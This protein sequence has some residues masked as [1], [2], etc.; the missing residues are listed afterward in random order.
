MKYIILLILL[1]L[2]VWAENIGIPYVAQIDDLITKI[3]VIDNQNVITLEDDGELKIWDYTNGHFNYIFPIERISNFEL[4]DDK[5]LLITAD[6]DNKIIFWNLKTKQNEMLI[7]SPLEYIDLMVLAQNNKK[8]ALVD[9]HKGEI[10]IVNLITEKVENTFHVS[11]IKK[12][13]FSENENQI[14]LLYENGEVHLMDLIDHGKNFIF[15]KYRVADMVVYKNKVICQSIVNGHNELLSIH[16]ETYETQNF[17]NQLISYQNFKILDKYL[18]LK[19]SNILHLLDLATYKNISSIPIMLGKD[20]EYDITIDRD[21][22]VLAGSGIRVIDIKKMTKLHELKQA[23]YIGK[24]D[25]S[26]D[27]KNISLSYY[28]NSMKLQ[29]YTFSLSN[30][31]MVS[32]KYTIPESETLIKRDD[33]LFLE[34]GKVI[35]V[36]STQKTNEE[37]VAIYN[38]KMQQTEVYFSDNTQKRLLFI[39]PNQLRL[40]FVSNDNSELFTERFEYIPYIDR[41]S[42]STIDRWNVQTGKLIQTLNIPTFGLNI[43]MSNNKKYLAYGDTYVHIYKKKDSVKLFM[44]D[45]GNWVIQIPDGSFI[46]SKDAR[47]YICMKMDDEQYVPINNEAYQKFNNDTK[48]KN[49]FN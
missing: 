16:L 11:G 17:F 35:S 29:K 8:V 34:E 24:I 19:S 49:Y 36:L 47:K 31:K 32:N 46:A 48:V 2:G 18:V 28:V 9:R 1:T 39:S 5:K 27:D 13:L 20:K 26:N 7:D 4:S 44:F 3:S 40:L 33:K 10:A 45:D 15:N 6:M 37:F 12:I 21:K 14:I 41:L 38:K 22:V 30:W 23:R 42:F 25:F 43:V